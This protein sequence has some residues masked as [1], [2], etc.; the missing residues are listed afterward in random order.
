[1]T[2]FK[3]GNRELK[4]KFGYEATVKNRIIR[5]L[6]ELDSGQNMDRIENILLILPE[7]LLVGVQKYHGE[8]FGFD[9]DDAEGKEQQLE[10]IYAILDDYF[11]TEDADIQKLYADLQKELVDN[12][13]LSKL[14]QAEK[15]K[16]KR[17][18]K[19]LEVQSEN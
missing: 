1:M 18:P 8:E 13:F 16:A 11:D 6:V 9:P 14:F 3:L 12:G 17:K 4:V 15:A 7:L 5:K 10:K 19:N 2:I